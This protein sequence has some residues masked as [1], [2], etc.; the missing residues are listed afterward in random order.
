MATRKYEQR[1]R[2]EAAEERRRRILDAVYERLRSAPSEP[3][4]VE[5]VA[6]MAGVARSTVYLT[7][8]SRAGLFDALGA[9]LLRRGGFVRLMAAVADPD[10]REGMRGGIRGGVEMYSAHRDVLRVLFSMAMLDADAVG[11]AVQRMEEGRA[12]GMAYLAR[13]LAEQGVLRPDVSASEAA[14][15]LWVVTSFDSFD[16]LY[17]GR[18]LSVDQ[19]ADRLVTA[20]ERALLR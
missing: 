12:G 9:D 6:R 3:V 5:R 8:G 10:A 11:G 14:E 13:R 19:V 7:F 1:L 15:L 4:S 2:A 18:G 16:L 20:A 17:A